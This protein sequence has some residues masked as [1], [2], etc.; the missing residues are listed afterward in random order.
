MQGSGGGGGTEERSTQLKFAENPVIT[1]QCIRNIAGTQVLPWG[2]LVF[3][4]PARW[5]EPSLVYCATALDPEDTK[6]IGKAEPCR[7]AAGAR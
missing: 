4:I 6:S 1:K 2:L 3:H 7:E 5:T